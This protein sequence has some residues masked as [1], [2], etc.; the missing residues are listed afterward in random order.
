MCCYNHNLALL[1]AYR[2][3]GHVLVRFYKL[4]NPQIVASSGEVVGYRSVLRPSYRWQKGWNHARAGSG[5]PMTR[6]RPF[7][8]YNTVG[9][10]L[11]AFLLRTYAAEERSGLETLQPVW[12]YADEITAVDGNTLTASRMLIKRFAKPTND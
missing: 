5:R 10:S 6:T 7:P 1:A 2:K 8:A 9:A 3:R 4:L 11:H 12:V